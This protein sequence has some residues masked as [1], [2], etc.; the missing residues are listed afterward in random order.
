MGEGINW[1]DEEGGSRSKHADADTGVALLRS[2]SV[3]SSRSG[4]ACI[5]CGLG[6][7]VGDGDIG[8][9]VF[10]ERVDGDDGVVEAEMV[11]VA[12]Q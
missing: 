3:A 12:G 2:G 9:E 6:L 8:G 10:R 5:G 4:R 1:L 11:G 7:A